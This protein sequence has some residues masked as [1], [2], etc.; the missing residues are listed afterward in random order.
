[1]GP[2]LLVLALIT[3]ALA[4]PGIAAAEADIEIV[5]FT[6]PP[7]AVPDEPIGDQIRLRIRNAGTTDI[8]TGFSVGF[9]ISAD[10]TITTGDQLLLGGR[11][12]VFSLAAGEE[13]EVPLF[14]GARIPPGYPLGP[15]YLG[16]IVD[17]FD[18]IPESDEWN[19]TASSLVE[20]VDSL[21]DLQIVTFT[22]PA[23]AVPDDPIGDQI[24]LR[25][26][27]EGTTDIT[28]SFS[29]GFYISGDAT[30]TMGDQL[31]LAGR[32]FVPSIAGGTEAYVPLTSEARIPPGYPPGPAYLG[33]IVDEFDAV[34]ESDEGNNTAASPVEV[35]TWTEIA[36]EPVTALALHGS[37]PNPFGPAT[38]IRYHVPTDGVRVTLR[39]FDVS[40]R[41]IRTLVDGN[42]PSGDRTATWNGTDARGNPVSPGVYFCRLEAGGKVLTKKM[43]LVE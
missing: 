15:A 1:M 25:I 42:V 3:V 38:A 20:V 4:L 31:L 8:T 19:N 6:A 29:V 21:P 17:E 27:N 5:T 9:Y 39:V 18:V 10:A 35:V 16:V 28:F 36:Q 13:V 43:V 37:F 32:E 24:Y 26:R 11:E 30:I 22:G 23:L 14:S 7:L 34:P 33:V 12:H 40:G 41:A 2:R